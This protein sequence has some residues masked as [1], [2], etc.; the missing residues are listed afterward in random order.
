MKVSSCTSSVYSNKSF[1][2]FKSQ[3]KCCP[4]TKTQLPDCN[5]KFEFDYGKCLKQLS[6]IFG[7][8]VVGVVGLVM[9]VKGKL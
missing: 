3:N 1:P 9:A 4:V 7:V 5:D 8:S 2:A 6:Y